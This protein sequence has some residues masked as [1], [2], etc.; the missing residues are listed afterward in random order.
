MAV[1]VTRLVCER[2]ADCS[3]RRRHRH[4]APLPPQATARGHG[5]RLSGDDG[6]VGAETGVRVIG[7]LLRSRCRH[8]HTLALPPHGG[9][10]VET[11]VPVISRIYYTSPLSTN[12]TTASTGHAAT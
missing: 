3:A 7:Q 2:S 12:C 9:V 11:G 4:T 6:S 10:G 1:L 5:R 8:R